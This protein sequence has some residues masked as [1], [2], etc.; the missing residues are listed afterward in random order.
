MGSL[1]YFVAVRIWAAFFSGGKGLPSCF[2]D[3]FDLVA[4]L[5]CLSMGINI[6]GVTVTYVA[7]AKECS[8]RNLAAK[9]ALHVLVAQENPFIKIQSGSGNE[10]A[11][12][13][14]GFVHKKGTCD[15]PKL[16]S[17]VYIDNRHRPPYFNPKTVDDKKGLSNGRA[18]LQT[19]RYA[20]RNNM[21]RRPSVQSTSE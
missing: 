10:P 9:K 5:W 7:I 16:S 6:K 2:V 3:F 1:L 19:K 12:I 4:A 8:L 17:P 21:S 15:L 20:N 11:A 13:Y 14:S 18:T